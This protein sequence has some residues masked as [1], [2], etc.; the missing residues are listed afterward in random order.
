[1]AATKFVQAWPLWLTQLS[2]FALLAVGYGCYAIKMVPAF[3]ILGT[4]MWTLSEILGAPTVWAYPGMVAP[5]NLRGRY[6]GAMQSMYGLGSTLGPILG[7]ALYDR[8]GQR[9]FLWAAAVALLATVIGRIGMRASEPEAKSVSPSGE[10]ILAE[11]A[12]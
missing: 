1:M 5:S 4:L 9:F 3:L 10:P 6:F 12:V 11:P 7:I 8:V 2:G